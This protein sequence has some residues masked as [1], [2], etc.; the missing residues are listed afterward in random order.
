MAIFLYGAYYL[1]YGLADAVGLFKEDEAGEMRSY[2]VFGIPVVLFGLAM[3]GGASVVVRFSFYLGERRSTSV[4]VPSTQCN[5]P[6]ANP[7]GGANREQPVGSDANQA[8]AAA[9]PRRSP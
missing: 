3:V 4:P 5:G 8:S 1:L 7:Q 9:A 2:L 6:A